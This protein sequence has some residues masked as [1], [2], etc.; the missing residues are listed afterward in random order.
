MK[1]FVVSLI[2]SSTFFL[3]FVNS[4][5]W[6]LRFSQRCCWRFRLCCLVSVF[7]NCEGL[8]CLYLQDYAALEV[9]YFRTP[10]CLETV[11]LEDGGTTIFRNVGKH[12]TTQNHIPEDLDYE[13]SRTTSVS[14]CIRITSIWFCCIFLSCSEILAAAAA[15]WTFL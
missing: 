13:F 5:V 1:V 2:S 8:E 15:G 7:R 10:Q 12:P 3:K 14:E 9:W 6:G 11:N 4:S